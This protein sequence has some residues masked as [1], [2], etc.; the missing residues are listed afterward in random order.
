MDDARCRELRISDGSE[1]LRGTSSR[2][3]QVRDGLYTFNSHE[4]VGPADTAEAVAYNHG[5]VRKRRISGR[6]FLAALRTRS[7]S[8]GSDGSWGLLAK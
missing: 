5:C 6:G 2:V 7:A 4:V 8:N 1:R 3:F